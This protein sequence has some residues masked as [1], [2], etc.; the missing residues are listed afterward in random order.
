MPR[1]FLL[2]AVAE[3]GYRE[4]VQVTATVQITPQKKGSA[5]SGSGHLLEALID[6]LQSR[7][8]QV[9]SVHSELGGRFYQDENDYLIVEAPDDFQIDVEDRFKWMTLGQIKTLLAEPGIFTIE[10]RSIISLLMRYI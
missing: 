3:I 2:Q 4:S 5:G 6:Q 7:H 10:A 8:A 1:H 9:S